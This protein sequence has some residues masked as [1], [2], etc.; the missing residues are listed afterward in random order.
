[1][2]RKVPYGQHF[3]RDRAVI[4]RIVMAIAPTANDHIVE[5]GAGQGAVTLPL[6]RAA[7][8]LTAIELDRELIGPLRARAAGLGELRI[9][10]ADALQVDL[11]ALATSGRL[12]LV[13]NLPYYASSPILF[14]CLAHAD[15]IADM[16]FM[17]QKEVVRRMAAAP[18]SKVYGRLSV[19]L[20]LACRVEALLD[21]AP[22][23]FRPP[24][25][26]DSMLV[27]LTPLPA[28][29]CPEPALMPAVTGIVRAAFGQRRKTL[30]N[31]LHGLLDAGAIRAAGVDPRARAENIAAD[32]FVEL[33]RR[34]VSGRLQVG[35]EL[36]DNAGQ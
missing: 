10:H 8:E 6:L 32:A 14:H 25:G 20:Q 30:A 27:R 36:V 4:E 17:L 9:I 15:A 35:P 18:G 21:V 11:T 16:H 19:M 31:A 13:G 24:P 28:A 5:I 34:A 33:A 23:A 1:M 12:R 3:L 26:V 22:A 29:K 2:R 7:G